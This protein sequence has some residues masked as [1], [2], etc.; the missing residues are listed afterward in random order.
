VSCS[1]GSAAPNNYS[2]MT[3]PKV[4]MLYINATSTINKASNAPSGHFCNDDVPPTALCKDEIVVNLTY[5]QTTGVLAALSG[6]HYT[7]GACRTSVPRVPLGRCT[8]LT[9]PNLV[10]PCR[11]RLWQ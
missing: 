4:H 3:A 7:I 10:N 6:N 8:L 1:A 2:A 9:I 5:A 11:Q